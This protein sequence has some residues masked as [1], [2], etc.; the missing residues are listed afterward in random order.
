MNTAATQ[1]FDTQSR[2]LEELNTS[3]EKQNRD[4]QLP[5]EMTIPPHVSP[6]DLPADDPQL[7]VFDAMQQQFEERVTNPNGL[8]ARVMRQKLDDA[9]RS[10]AGPASLGADV[11]QALADLEL[12]SKRALDTADAVEQEYKK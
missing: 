4:A 3:I 5:P 7:L 9:R 11:S 2:A 1:A 10:G 12:A 6:A 8:V